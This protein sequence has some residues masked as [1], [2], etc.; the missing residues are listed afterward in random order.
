MNRRRRATAVICFLSI[1]MAGCAISP[2]RASPAPEGFFSAWAAPQGRL[3]EQAPNLN[4]STVRVVV[5]PTIDGTALRIKLENTIAKTPVTF[6]AVYVGKLDRDAT[7]ANGTNKPLTFGG[8][9]KVTLAPGAGIYSD[10]IDFPVKAFQ[11]L[12]VSMDVISA[13][14]VSTH[15]LGLASNYY[16]AGH[17]AQSESGDG[18]TLLPT[19]AQNAVSFP[20]YW[21]AALDVKSNATAGTIVALGDSITDGRCS[22]TDADG[23]VVPDLY[24][25]WTDILAE[26]LASMPKSYAKAVVNS[27]IAGNRVLEEAVTGP[28]A[29]ARFDRDVLDRAGIT[30]IILFEGTNDIHRGSTAAEL[31]EGTRQLIDRAHARGVKIIG[32]TMIPRG[33]PEVTAREGFDETKERYRLEFNEWVRKQAKFDSIIDFEAEMLGGGTSAQGAQIMKREYSCDFVHPNGAGHRALGESID[34]QL[35]Q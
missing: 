26:R 4:D 1:G 20:V 15:A 17:R 14:E 29:L 19:R 13:T 21:V 3:A 8:Q 24:Q 32:A 23:N 31:I 22:T 30:H 28:P 34:L 33:Q 10:V 25:R 16:A 9:S 12:A 5:R 7:L 2:E 18:F 6:A 35:F 11:R 27:G